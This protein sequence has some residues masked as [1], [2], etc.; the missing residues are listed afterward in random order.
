MSLDNRAWVSRTPHRLRERRCRHRHMMAQ[1]VR[2]RECRANAPPRVRCVFRF[3]LAAA[4]LA[5][6]DSASSMSEPSSVPV[7]TIHLPQGNWATVLDALC[8]CFASIPRDQWLDRMQRGK[9]RDAEGQP[10]DPERQYAPGMCVRYFRELAAETPIP[11]SESVLHVDEH[12]VIADKPH[13]LPVMPAGIYARETLLTRLIE[14]LGNPALVPLHR[15]DRATSG[16][17]MLSCN[18]QTRAHYQELF[19]QRRIVKRYEALA[20]ALSLV[21]PMVRRSRLAQGPEFF[22]AQEVPGEPNSET[23]IDIVERCGEQARYALT[24]VTGRKHQLR[25]HLAALGAP[26]INDPLYPELLPQGPDDYTRPL[27]LLARSLEFI[28]PLTGKPRRFES[29]LAL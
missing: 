20:P 15:I 22:R 25:V 11:F 13:F 21:F 26:I 6:H 9:V 27:K 3:R 2:T 16:L 1:L 8:A 24:P 4:A 29:Q 10:I 14:R 7:S 5:R 28:D 18:P 23:T 12:L 19:R 17:V